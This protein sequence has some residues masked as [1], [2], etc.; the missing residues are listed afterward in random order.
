MVKEELIRRS[1]LRILERSIHG[2]LEKGGIG[3]IASPKG[4]GKTACLVHIAT[5]QLF[6]QRHVIHVSFAGRTDHIVDWYEEIFRE[7]A[8]KRDL[9]NVLQI[10]DELIRNRV[11]MNFSHNRVSL[12]H[13]FKSIR[14]MI[15]DGHFDADVLVIDGFEFMQHNIDDLVQFRQFARELNLSLWFSATVD[16]DSPPANENGVPYVLTHYLDSISVLITLLPERSYITLKLI[17]DHEQYPSENLHLTLDPR[18][19]LIVPE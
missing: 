13:V 6:Q 19:L 16:R 18:T 10:H 1:P 5:D 17:K 9:D 4:I 8:H 7:I 2:A 15:K 12:Q 3:I 11:I 14:S